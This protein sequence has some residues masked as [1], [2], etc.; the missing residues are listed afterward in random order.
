MTYKRLLIILVAIILGLL[1]YII[2][3]TGKDP[4]N[5]NF[6]RINILKDSVQT[7]EDKIKKQESYNEQLE[8]KIHYYETLP[9]KIK[10]VYAKQKQK[11]PGFTVDQ[12]DSVIRTNSG[13][14]RHH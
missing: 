9:P 2:L 4:Q 1:I 7:L 5:V 11:L 10:Y 8:A 6:D 13:L 12:L 14:Q 3:F